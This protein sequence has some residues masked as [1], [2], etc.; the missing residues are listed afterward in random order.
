MWKDLNNGDK[1][2]NFGFITLL[3][4]DYKILA[5]ALTESLVFVDTLAA[6]A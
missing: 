5:K 4:A 6:D 1:I 3:E 2:Y